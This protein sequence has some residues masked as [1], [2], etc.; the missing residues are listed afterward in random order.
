MG[1]YQY[2]VTEDVAITR[3]PFSCEACRVSTAPMS[4]FP[5]LRAECFGF[6]ASSC[7]VHLAGASR[8]MRRVC[9]Y[10]GSCERLIAQQ[11]TV[12]LQPRSRCQTAFQGT[13]NV[14]LL[15]ATIF[16]HRLNFVLLHRGQGS[17]F[18]P[19][20]C[21]VFWEKQSCRVSH[22]PLGCGDVEDSEESSSR[23]S[24]FKGNDGVQLFLWFVG[25]GAL[26]GV[27]VTCGSEAAPVLLRP[28]SLTSAAGCL[29]SASAPG[30]LSRM[31]PLRVRGMCIL[32]RATVCEGTGSFPTLFLFFGSLSCVLQ[33]QNISQRDR[34]LLPPPTAVDAVLILCFC[35]TLG[36]F[37]L[38]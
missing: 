21:C 24:T 4:F 34:E 22:S 1:Q 2:W 11:H 3:P 28:C 36:N 8:A 10:R 13:V 27:I 37:R 29:V 5:G 26:I 18:R 19:R 30:C 31:S 35:Q 7:V 16:R 38:Q 6:A 12:V 25:P 20:H 23:S 32:A 15:C 9:R 14:S 33:S 17:V